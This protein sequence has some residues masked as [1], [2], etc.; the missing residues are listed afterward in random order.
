MAEERAFPR[1]IV[2]VNGDVM[3]MEDP[4]M[5]LR[6]YFA[7]KALQGIAGAASNSVLNDMADGA[8]GFARGSK[9]AYIMADAMLAEREK[10]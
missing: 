6:D 7:A 9:V 5:T 4:G 8:L 10:K 3:G 2:N 1:T